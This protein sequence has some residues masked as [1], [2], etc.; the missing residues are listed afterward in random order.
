MFHIFFILTFGRMFL[1]ILH[2]IK[3]DD[4]HIPS[5]VVAV[6]L[7]FRTILIAALW[8]WILIS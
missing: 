3:S 1:F 2:S 8:I 6:L 4:I 7:V 5:A